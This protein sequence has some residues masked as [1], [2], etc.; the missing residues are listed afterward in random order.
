MN[1]ETDLL[2]IPCKAEGRVCVNDIMYT[3]MSTELEL[4]LKLV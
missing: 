2:V 1:E 3:Y 4:L